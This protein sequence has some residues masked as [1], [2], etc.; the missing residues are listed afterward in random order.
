MKNKHK[1]E[2]WLAHIEG[3]TGKDAAD[4]LKGTQFYCDRSALPEL[5]EKEIYF[6]DLVGMTCV[7]E[8]GGEFATV[9]S[10]HNFGAG[11]LLE[12]TPINGGQSF[13]ISYTDDT[14]LEVSDKIT[15]RMPGIV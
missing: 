4:A 1:G 9:Q 11:D 15:V 12:V 13:F 2:I 10:T 14:I 6:A 8:N 3:V 7:D 5:S